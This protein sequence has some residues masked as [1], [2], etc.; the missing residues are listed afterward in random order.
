[1]KKSEKLITYKKVDET[2]VSYIRTCV[3]TRDEI[4]DTVRTLLAQIPKEI[5]TGPAYG[6][7]IWVT[8]VPQDSGFDMEIGIPVNTEFEN[9]EILSRI[10]E[11]REVISILHTGSIE[12][13]NE[14][15][16][17][18]F[19]YVRERN[20]ISDEFMLEIFLDDNNPKGQELELQFVV[21]NWQKLFQKHTERVLGSNAIK[22]VIPE[23]LSYDSSA[24]ERLIWAKDAIKGV[25]NHTSDNFQVYDILSSCA[26]VFPPSPIVKMKE[27]YE[28]GMRETNN[29]LMAI[30]SVLDMMEADNAWGNRPIRKGNVIIATKNPADRV[31]FEKATTPAEKRRAA[32]FC[33]VIRNNLGDTDIPKEYCLCSAGWERRQWEGALSTPVKVDVRKSVLQSDDF[34]QFAIHIPEELTG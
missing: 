29:S 19:K 8:S 14:T 25:K 31:A 3:K 27:T 4:S 5:I 26:H 15:L 1:M 11:G 24:D 28:R 22:G 34:C 30:D 18:L 13:K 17:I 20:I 33:P 7:T 10:L 21:H 12:T 16:K 2:R 9:D 6:R 32:C 23:Q